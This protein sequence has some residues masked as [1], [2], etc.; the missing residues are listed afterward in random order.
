MQKKMKQNLKVENTNK[1]KCTSVITGCEIANV[2]NYILAILILY[3]ALKTSTG[4]FD[5]GK[6]PLFFLF[7]LS[8]EIVFFFS[9]SLQQHFNDMLV[10][11]KIRT[12]KVTLHCLLCYLVV[13]LELSAC[14]F[15]ITSA[16]CLLPL[17]LSERT[18]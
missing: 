7:R 2:G 14:N 6:L 10:R 9:G 5:S 3:G 16:K 17:E 15:S 18:S 8:N 11:A 4:N 1:V 13:S 12:I